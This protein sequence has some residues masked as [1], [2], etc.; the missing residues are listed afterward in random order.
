[1]LGYAKSEVRAVTQ[2]APLVLM[3]CERPKAE[4]WINN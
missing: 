1:M 4:R 2:S 3:I